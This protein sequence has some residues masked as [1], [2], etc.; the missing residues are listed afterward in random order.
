MFRCFFW[1]IDLSQDVNQS[2]EHALVS[3]KKYKSGFSIAAYC[4][5]AA[6]SISTTFAVVLMYAAHVCGVVPLGCC[7]ALLF[8]LLAVFVR[9]AVEHS[10]ENDILFLLVG[11]PAGI[12]F[13][14]FILPGNVPDEY[15]HVWQVTAL[16]SRSGSGFMVPSA[17]NETNMPHSFADMYSLITKAPNWGDTFLCGRYLSS[18]LPFVYVIASIPM[19][20]CRLV[21][22]N[23]YLAF[24]FARLGNLVF[25]LISATLLI[26]Y[27]KFGKRLLLVYF[28]NPMLIQQE[29]SCSGDA[30]INIVLFSFVIITISAYTE[31]RITRHRAICLAILAVLLCLSKAF[32][33]SPFL[34][35]LL[36]FVP[37]RAGNWTR[38]G[39]W[40]GAFT[41]VA[42]ASV[43]IIVLYRGP[44]MQMGFE[45]LRSPIAF[46]K[47]MVKTIW[48]MGP[49][50]V[51]SFAGYNLGALS[52]NVW[53]PCFWAYL[54]LLA[55]V[56]VDDE[57]RQESPFCLD[58][59]L[60][61]WLI[62]AID[63][64]LIC[65]SM[66]EW[67]VTIDGRSDIFMGVQGRYFIPLVF[68]PLFSIM[69]RKGATRAQCRQIV[70]VLALAA[71]FCI[72][73]LCIVQFF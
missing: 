26:R 47:V 68:L 60:L 7:I 66:R 1:G 19:S 25:Y 23:E 44:F 65:L 55:L 13:C 28:L 51:E 69:E 10:A 48:E 2:H 35:L 9:L 63:V 8:G 54:V 29:A 53:K 72:D 30:V 24:Y 12:A 71:I 17:L 21:G 50:W 11:V 18:Y 32:A 14:L 34:L 64:V 20:V 42:I 15:P 4:V 49:F 56:S 38:R 43:L 67:T 6:F 52:I 40:I 3:E 61:L 5:Y 62:P 31:K 22:T 16:F 27:T 36:L 46:I 41:A 70:F 33:Y 37:E 39:I 59:R 58:D 45:L 73:M 57:G